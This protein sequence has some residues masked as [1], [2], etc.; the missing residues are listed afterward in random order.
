MLVSTVV[1]G[2]ENSPVCIVLPSAENVAA[3]VA[4]MASLE[5]LA[6]DLPASR[7]KY[8][9]DLQPGTRLRLLPNHEV[10]EL[11]E[12][13]DRCVRLR[14]VDVRNYRTNGVR[15]LKREQAHWFEPTDRRYPFG[16]PGTPIREPPQ[17][18]LDTL[19]GTPLYGNTGLIETRV[20]LVGTLAGFERFLNEVQVTSS[21][22]SSG[23]TWT[24]SEKKAWS[25]GAVFPIGRL[26]ADGQPCVVHPRGSAGHPLVAI[27]RDLADIRKACLPQQVP[28]RSRVVVTDRVDAVLKD[29]D[30]AGRIA[31]RQRFLLIADARRR[32]DLEPLRAQGWVV[33]E[34]SS[35][36]I[37]GAEQHPR[38]IG[39]TGVD[40]SREAADTEG[41]VTPQFVACDSSELATADAQLARLADWLGGESV[42]DEPWAVDL[43]DSARWLFFGAASWLSPPR[44]PAQEECDRL[45]DRIRGEH[46]RLARRLGA[47][48]SM[49]LLKF[50]EAI[51]EFCKVL[52]KDEASPKGRHLW[53]AR[54]DHGGPHHL[55]V[56]G[57][58]SAR[59]EADDFFA[60]HGLGIRALSVADL[61]G[62]E[63]HSIVAF[64][65][66]RRDAFARLVDPWPS[67][68][69]TFLGYDF[70]LDCY[71]RRLVQ[72]T[73]LRAARVIDVTSRSRMTSWP[74]SEFTDEQQPAGGSKIT[75]NPTL[76]RFDLAV[77]ISGR[78]I[79]IPKAGPNEETDR[80]TVVRF[81]GR[82]WCGMTDEHRV[83]ALDRNPSGAST[84]VNHVSVKELAPGSRIVVREGHDRDVI[85][86]I[87][88]Q[89]AGKE[90]YSKVRLQS[91]LWRQALRAHSASPSE[92][93]QRLS[94][95]GVRRNS[96]T[97]RQWLF[98]ESLIAPRSEEDILAIA[99]AFPIRGKTGKDWRACCEAA[100]KLRA[101]HG[102][103][104]FRLTEILV[105]RCGRMLLEPSETE[106]AIDL[107]LGFVWILEVASIDAD[108]QDCPSSIS[109]RLQWSDQDW[110]DRLLEK[111][112]RNTA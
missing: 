40:R 2:E 75:V 60:R 100:Q 29:L 93:E 7:Q 53:L 18:H 58:R 13:D 38:K 24:L 28:V 46:D 86:L 45:L 67:R 57:S 9:G 68:N 16:Q 35:K 36:D 50:A 97:I 74:S 88:E 63:A 111:P 95:L 62:T 79:S 23:R 11:G 14:L 41:K 21:D 105:K 78:K 19:V 89:M 72:R 90:K 37:L 34:L 31:E 99:E 83:L 91:S 59:E 30:T 70:E 108:Q 61:P 80:V 1:H 51:E 22:L 102:R 103:A 84:S 49:T 17:S 3:M 27:E 44:G 8:P 81:V 5:L 20:L 101:L 76:H 48:A 104:G 92:V 107:S 56:A 94:A 54:R 66:I 15:V 33:W 52:R 32:G 85:R 47:E 4:A 42:A 71:R 109:N 64:S 77:G 110:R 98:N 55:F 112:L 26:D 96:L 39:C 82:S 12:V 87:A 6:R 65:M 73:A 106:L 69:M 43:L 25:L 10:F